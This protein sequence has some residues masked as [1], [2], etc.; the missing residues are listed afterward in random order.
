MRR[1]LAQLGLLAALAFAA[2]A[3]LKAQGEFC[4]SLCED[5]WTQCI[6]E[7]GSW[8]EG[9]FCPNAYDPQTQICDIDAACIYGN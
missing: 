8:D 2:T 6:Q 9:F 4:L 7:G 3:P 5:Q 1:R